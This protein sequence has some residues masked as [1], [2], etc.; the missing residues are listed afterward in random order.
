M[1]SGNFTIKPPVRS[2]MC[3]YEIYIMYAS[4]TKNFS[5]LSSLAVCILQSQQP[6]WKAAVDVLLLL[7]PQTTVEDALPAFVDSFKHGK[8]SRRQL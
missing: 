3:Q 4:N 7:P 5:S 1:A 6:R 2:S 8:S